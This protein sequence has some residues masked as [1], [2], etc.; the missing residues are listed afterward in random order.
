MVPDIR[1]RAKSKE[2]EMEKKKE[3][4]K[5]KEVPTTTCTFYLVKK[6]KYCKFPRM[7]NSVYCYHHIGLENP[8]DYMKCP[9]DPT[10]FIKTA[11]VEVHLKICT[12][13]KQEYYGS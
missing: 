10:H 8:V 2:A 9:A 4:G 7:P 12:K 11:D 13:A 1:I 5:R 6:A 3:K